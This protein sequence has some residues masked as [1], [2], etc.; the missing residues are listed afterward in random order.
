MC[1][2][3]LSAAQASEGYFELCEAELSP[4]SERARGQRLAAWVVRTLKGFR[5]CLRY[6]SLSRVVS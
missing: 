4:K 3:G 6:K 5:D 1:C 2:N